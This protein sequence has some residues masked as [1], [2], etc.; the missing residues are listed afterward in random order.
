[1]YKKLNST[2]LLIEINPK[3][4]DYIDS[5]KDFILIKRNDDDSE[6]IIDKN[7]NRLRTNIYD[8]IGRCTKQI[9]YERTFDYQFSIEDNNQFIFIYNTTVINQFEG[10][11]FKPKLITFD[12][13]WIEC[14]YDFNDNLIEA[15]NSNDSYFKATYINNKLTKKYFQIKS[16][17]DELSY[18][19]GYDN[20]NFVEYLDS[21]NNYWNKNLQFKCPYETPKE[22]QIKFN[23]YKAIY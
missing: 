18:S 13:F 10:D 17:D 4:Y 16:G 22:I 21:N 19:F 6:N 15:Y 14:E 7:F 3:E 5:N 8:E 12:D 20:G 2:S 11:Y 9:I 23:N 1:M